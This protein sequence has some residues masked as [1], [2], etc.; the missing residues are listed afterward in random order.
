MHLNISELSRFYQELPLGGFVRQVLNQQVGRL[1]PD[2]KDRTILGFGYA[3]PLH[4]SLDAAYRNIYLMPQ[5]QGSVRHA[6][7]RGNMAVSCQDTLWPIPTGG[8]ELCVIMHG[9]ETSPNGASLL[10]ECWRVLAPE[11]MVLIIVPNRAGFWARRDITPFGHGRPYSAS[12]LE[13][14]V[15]DNKFEP[16]CR[17]T[18]LF[19]PPGKSG[20]VARMARTIE[21]HASYIPLGYTAGVLLCMARKRVFSRHRTGIG[22]TVKSRIASLQAGGIPD[23][24]S[25]RQSS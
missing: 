19:A 3:T 13:T 18:A 25:G 21:R 9:L 5:S 2:V 23:P 7:P 14:L 22:E 4:D 8:I 1:W 12:Q 17:S 24:A 11:G 15:R 10:T 6:G 16:V 20:T